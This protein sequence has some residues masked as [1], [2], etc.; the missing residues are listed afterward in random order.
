MVPVISNVDKKSILHLA[1]E[2]ADLGQR[3]RDRKIQVEEFQG[4]SFSLTNIGSIG[5]KTFTPILNYPDSAILGVGRTYEKP[6]VKDGEIMVASILPLCLTFDHRVTDGATAA[7]FINQ[8]IG[9][10]QDPDLL[11]LEDGED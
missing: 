7:R 9:Y 3:A 1:S 4:H 11:L 10:L 6:V 2:L 5:G 8:I